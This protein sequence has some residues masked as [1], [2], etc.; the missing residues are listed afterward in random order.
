[1]AIAWIYGV[2]RFCRDVEF[3]LQ[4]PIGL[5]WRICWGFITPTMMIIILIYTIVKLQPLTYRDQPYPT[6]A[7]IAGWILFSVGVLQFP[8]WAYYAVR[9]QKGERLRERIVSSCQPEVNW[10]PLDEKLLREYREFTAR[11]TIEA[12]PHLKQMNFF[13][14][15]RDRIFN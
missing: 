11:Y 5:Y 15:I 9:Q 3:M 12:E 14:K 10:G 13:E 4:K 2:K 8:I 6:S 1:M 7:Y